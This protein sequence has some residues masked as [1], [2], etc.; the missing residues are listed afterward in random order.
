MNDI[1]QLLLVITSIFLES[2]FLNSLYGSNLNDLDIQQQNIRTITGNV[3]TADGEP[4]P[5]A[6]IIAKGTS[7]GIVT[8]ADG[9]FT[10]RIPA[11]VQILQI[12]FIGMKTQEVNVRGKT[13]ISVIMEEEAVALEEVVA[14]GYGNVRRKDLTGAVSSVSGSSLQDIPV[15]STALAIRGRMPGVQVTQTEGSPDAEIKIRVRGGGSLTQDNSPL[16]IV[17]GFPVDNINDIA[18]TDI[19]SIDVLKDASSSAIYGA[20]GAN[21]V[22]LITTKSGFEE[23]GKVSYN[24][25]F[26]VKN[27]TK[28]LDILSPYEFVNWQYELFSENPERTERYFGDYNDY[29]LYKQIDGTN[30]Q[31][32]ILGRTGSSMF[33]NLS[34]SGGSK[35]S[36]YN[37]S[38]TR[39]DEKEIMIGS[40]F[41]RTNL[42][43]KTTQKVNNWL[44]I[45]LNTTLSDTSLKGTGTSENSRLMHVI[46]FRPIE[47]IS[48]F[49]D[50]EV[51]EGDYG[52]ND[53]FTVNPLK[54]TN[55]DYRRS[56]NLVFNFNGAATINFTKNF[57]YRF[58]YGYRYGKDAAERFWGINTTNVINF[59]YQPIASIEKTDI[60][61]FR[62]SNVLTYDKKDF[63]QN[64]NLNIMLGEELYSYERENIKSSAKYFPKYIDAAHALRMMNLGI[65]DPIVTTEYPANKFSSF[66]GRLNYDYK[67]RYLASVTFR[68]DGSSKFAPGNQ[69]GYFPSVALAWRISDENFMKSTRQWLSD[70]KVRASYGAAGNNRISDEA[71]KKTLKTSTGK[72]YMEG[73]ETIPTTFLLPDNI[74]SNRKLKWE[75]M[76]TQNIGLDA[77]VLNQRFNGSV[78]VY[79]NTTQDLLIKATIPSSSGYTL[80]WQNIGQTSNRG[81]EVSLNGEVL[82]TKDIR[83][84]MSFNIGFN[85]NRIDKLGDTKSWEQTSG[86]SKSGPTGDYL[87]EEGGQIGLMYGYETEGMYT[88]DDFNYENGVYGLKEGVADD[89]GLIGAKR[90]WPGALKL[91]DQNGDVIVDAANDK[92]II[93]NAN[94]KNSGGFS[95]E[96]Q[97]KNFDFSAFFNWVYG[98]DIYNANKILFTSWEGMR[99]YRNLL[100]IMN[101]NSRFTYIDRTTGQEVKDPVQL[102]GMNENATIWSA[103]MTQMPLHSWA[104]EDGSFL[105]LNNLTIGYSLS[106]N[107]LKNLKIDQF[108]I[109]VVAYNLWTWTKYSGYDPEV[110]TQ[111]STPLTPGVDFCAYPRSR[112]F[113]IGFNLKF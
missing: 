68:A 99:P 12:S 23:K 87:I 61:S 27:I 112:S 19:A 73:N 88:F 55:D 94:P 93:G 29:D 25:Y 81:V 47:G 37:V 40:G 108:R 58:E 67:K 91:K 90:F 42:L 97:F 18:P 44:K 30:W 15:T 106:K 82:R 50:A 100:N 46:T 52:I 103:A 89:S 10:L 56:K 13:S 49:L 109:Y 60:K 80:Q 53:S 43:I 21:G 48:D 31:D 96:S 32:E 75:T 84:S 34:I 78:E 98:N 14:V 11:E 4:L 63:I 8:D 16:Y 41:S 104:I 2:L 26:G 83:L 65:P 36:T 39:N 101:S 7:Q 72:L 5:G 64:H 70:L 102:T 3:K 107:W 105:R 9:N 71:W 69:W 45:N 113:N 62:L 20:R 92:V 77:G 17:D 51:A 66:F 1:K 74:L 6:T 24:S 86:W 57:I 85:K 110:D 79:K 28:T 35:T 76:V 95:L 38:L 111:R 59:G 54:Q 33:H 22:I